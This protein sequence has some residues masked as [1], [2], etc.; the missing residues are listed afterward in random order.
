MQYNCIVWL[1]V[2]N[3]QQNKDFAHLTKALFVCLLIITWI[4]CLPEYVIHAVRL[5]QL[6][7]HHKMFNLKL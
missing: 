1:D 4:S 5:H 7:S 2:S 6:N 3:I